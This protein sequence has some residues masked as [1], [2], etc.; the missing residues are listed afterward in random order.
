VSVIIP[1]LNEEKNLPYVLPRIPSWVDEILLVDS[2]STDA[3]VAVARHTRP[4]IRIVQ[5]TGKGKG[6]A[7]QTGFKESTGDIIIMLDA[8]GST[9]PAEIPEFCALLASA[10]FVK[11][12][13]F[14][15]GGG[16]T[17]MGFV[18]KLGNSCLRILV[19]L[20]FGGSF[21]DLCYGY[22]G[23]RR[24]ALPKLHVDADGFEVETLMSIRA[25]RTNLKI[26]EVP[27][28]EYRRLTGSSNLRAVRDG[29]RILRT[30]LKE[31]V[32]SPLAHSSHHEPVTIDEV[33]RRA[34]NRY[35][36]DQLAGVPQG[37]ETK[38]IGFRENPESENR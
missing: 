36:P 6:A 14:M 22:I 35:D 24:S 12:S 31:W 2:H 7:L 33:E 19:H 18:R 38:E 15:Q 23:F 11:G 1:A 21:S 5:Q 13:R 17:D 4:G 29:W 25:L 26:D 9:D 10:D 27:S 20:L 34:R 16:T 37:P 30:I 8:D 3:T 28:F 32:H